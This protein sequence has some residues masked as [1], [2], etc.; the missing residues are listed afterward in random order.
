MDVGGQ[1][2]TIFGHNHRQSQ[3]IVSGEDRIVGAFGSGC[4]SASPHYLNGR[5]RTK[6]HLGT[7]IATLSTTVSV[8]NLLFQEVNGQI[9]T[10]YDGRRFHD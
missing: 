7:A 9:I 10:D 4:L 6:E 5:I 3:H 8:T 1:V 2:W